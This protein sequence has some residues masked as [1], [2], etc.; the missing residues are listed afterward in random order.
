MWTYP[1]PIVSEKSG[2]R[3]ASGHWRPS[4]RNPGVT[5]VLTV[6]H[7]TDQAKARNPAGTVRAA[8]VLLAVVVSLLAAATPAVADIPAGSRDPGWNG[9]GAAITDVAGIGRA[10]AAVLQPDGKVVATGWAETG[11]RGTFGFT[12]VR[13]RTDGKPDP[14]FGVT[15]TVVTDF[16]SRAN[17]HA[18]AFAIARQPDGKL[19]V[20]GRLQATN[21]QGGWNLSWAVARYNENGSLDNGFGTAGVVEVPMGDECNPDFGGWGTAAYGVAIQGSKIVLAGCTQEGNLA[22]FA[23][24]RLNPNGTLD[25]GTATDQNPDDTPFGTAGRVTT[26][27]AAP[28]RYAYAMSLVLDNGGIVVG[29]YANVNGIDQLALLRYGSDGQPDTLFGNGHRFFPVKDGGRIL[30]LARQPDGKIVA[31][32]PAGTTTAPHFS[33]TR[34]TAT[35]QVDT[36]FGGG[37][38]ETSFAPPQ[39][40]HAESYAG[41]LAVRADGRIFVA[42]SVSDGGNGGFGVVRLGPTG[43]LE[44]EFMG[45]GVGRAFVPLESP[46]E[47]KP[48]QV[49][50]LVHD[51]KVLVAGAGGPDGS[52]GGDFATV[53]LFA[54][55]VV[56]DRDG[57]GVENAGDNCPDTSNPGQADLDRDGSGDACDDDDDADG[58][59]DLA[60]NCRV[61]VNPDQANVDGD[62]LGDACDD[63][64]DNDGR[65]DIA[66][67]C[68]LTSNADQA[69]V[70][71]DGVGD[72]CDSDND[73][74]GVA[75][76]SDNCR[77]TPNS[78]QK[79]LD[80]DGQG[81]ACDPDD[82]N[83]GVPDV[84]DKC[85]AA[86]H[87]TADGCPTP[88]PPS[89]PLRLLFT[90]GPVKSGRATTN[91]VSIVLD[92]KA[93]KPLDPNPNGATVQVIC[94]KG[95][96]SKKYKYKKGSLKLTE[97]DHRSF[98]VGSRFIIRTY[99]KKPAARGR[100]YRYEVQRR[101]GRVL[102]VVPDPKEYTP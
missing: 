81:D 15:G 39:G 76:T 37:T 92:P 14:G 27:V 30:A 72:G 101:R 4:P 34:F 85:P 40:I 31:A 74:D 29:G 99:R 11:G 65:L 10:H 67:N 35:G 48:S 2:R 8:L 3:R 83:D 88:P 55:K 13:Y 86:A 9:D 78:E 95:C 59:P 23:L 1:S 32:G 96:K 100:E 25:D 61:I 62:D 80:R 17:R 89:L 66:D 22:K 7:M 58:R 98:K 38:V 18:Q 21:G 64:N 33:V 102:W 93:R 71:G 82:D 97:L 73:N 69:D 51:D 36:G 28:D 56:T 42:G 6:G 68:R 84:S 94:Q 43:A 26:A 50:V 46:P 5:L 70:D 60:D 79:D 19:V 87:R 16:G 90:N 47:F 57:D 54:D 91:A 75:D 53:R 63:D 12:T 45:D 49:G 41:G 52:G 77:L 24:V 44:A 20:A